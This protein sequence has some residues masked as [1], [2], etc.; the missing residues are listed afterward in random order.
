MDAMK[1]F[2]KNCR[3]HLV[4]LALVPDVDRLRDELVR[5]IAAKVRE[6]SGLARA[7]LARAG[8]EVEAFRALS[9]ERYGA[10]LRGQKGNIQ[11]LSFDGTLKVVR[12]ME[13]RIEF[14]ERLS[15]A[16]ELIGQCIEE[17][18]EGS[19]GEVRVLVE[20]AFRA[21]GQGRL[22]AGR[23]LG[24]RRLKIDDPRWQQAMEAIADAAQVVGTKAYLRVYERTAPDGEWR[25]IAIG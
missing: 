19:R 24:L 16:R 5:E 3:G 22:S 25:Q 2:F 17:W 14:D 1:G 8:G 7:A 4:P 9:A 20:D 18:T 13:E 23:V 12:A 21:D 15:A 11:L 6:L 10:K